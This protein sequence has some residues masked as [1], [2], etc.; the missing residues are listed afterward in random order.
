MI[1]C[2]DVENFIQS[3]MQKSQDGLWHCICCGKSSRVKTNIVEH[4]EA[5][6]LETPGYSCDICAKICKTRNALRSHKYRDHNRTF[7]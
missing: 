1:L 6:H 4:I 2:L 3:N 7:N 5:V